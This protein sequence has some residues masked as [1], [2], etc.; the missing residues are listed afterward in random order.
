MRVAFL[1]SWLLY[2]VTT[3][4]HAGVPSLD[5]TGYAEGWWGAVL[6]LLIV[7]LLRLVAGWR[8]PA[9]LPPSATTDGQE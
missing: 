3:A 7:S 6:W 8:T 1:V 2:W 9:P 4:L 5:V